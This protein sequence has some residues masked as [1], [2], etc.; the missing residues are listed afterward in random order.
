MD[1]SQAQISIENLEDDPGIRGITIKREI[2]PKLKTKKK[3]KEKSDDELIKSWLNV[4]EKYYGMKDIDKNH[5]CTYNDCVL[6]ESIFTIS[7]KRSIYG[8]ISSGINRWQ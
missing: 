7:E 8:C 4:R 5:S 1:W 3:L 2:I 6:N